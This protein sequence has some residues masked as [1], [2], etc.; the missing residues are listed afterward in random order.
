MSRVAKRARRRLACRIVHGR[1]RFSGVILDLSA[2]GMFVQTSAKPRPGEAVGIEISLPGHREPLRVD[3]EVARLRLVP[4]Q[5]VIVAQGGVGLRIT[6]APEAYFA[7]LSAVLPAKLAAPAPESADAAAPA[8]HKY[9]VRMS[10]VGGARSRTLRVRAHSAREAAALAVE[11]AG[12]GWKLL[13]TR[14]DDEAG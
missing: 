2:S 11:E 5:L 14:E 12:E 6:S 4:G 7:F 8:L 3:A 1:Q 9:R 13:E 10:Q